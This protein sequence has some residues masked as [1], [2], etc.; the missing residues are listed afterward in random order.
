M[1][2]YILFLISEIISKDFDINNNNNN[3]NNEDFE[4]E[5]QLTIVCNGPNTKKNQNGFCEC[6]EGYD[7]G[8]PSSKYGCYKCDKNCHKNAT[9][10]YPGKCNCLHGLIGDG[11]N[12]CKIPIPSIISTNLTKINNFNESILILINNPSNYSKEIYIKFGKLILNG[13]FLN[14]T[15]ILC[16]SPLINSSAI[17]LSISFD[18]TNWSN[19]LILNFQNSKFYYYY[20]FLIILII[21]LI[22]ILKNNKKIINNK[23]YLIEEITP[24]NKKNNNYLKI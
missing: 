5:I 10:I 2:V 22:I 8:D 15:S 17:K 4:P 19:E 21:I 18:S 14:S 9:C 3:N 16:F 11:I 24:F 23:N 6:L 12:N 1:Y 7:I 20:Y 13:I